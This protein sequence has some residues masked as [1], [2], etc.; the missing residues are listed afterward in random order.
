MQPQTSALTAI[1]AHF[2]EKY[3]QADGQLNRALL[4]QRVF[5]HPA[6]KQWLNALLHP[7]IREQ[8]IQQT[9]AAA[10]PYCLLVAPLLIENKL[11]QLVDRVLV[12]D[13][14]ESTQLSR[15][16]Q[17]DTSS[18]AEIKAIMASQ[19]S[20]QKRIEKAHEIINN[21]KTDLFSLKKEVYS[22]DLLYKK[23]VKQ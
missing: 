18:T 8:I 16:L 1:A 4:R 23:L 13:V 9:D 22:L 15:T 21:D 17:R 12:I 2:G 10:S 14:Q 11:H 3:I 7:L 19:I 6:D 5:S 20:R